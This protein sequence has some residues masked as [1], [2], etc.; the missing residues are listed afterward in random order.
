MSF[1]FT[2][3]SSGERSADVR[4]GVPRIPSVHVRA[5]SIT[6]AN[7]HKVAIGIFLPLIQNA[8]KQIVLNLLPEHKRKQEAG[9]T[10]FLAANRYAG[11]RRL[12]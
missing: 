7:V 9:R 11:L 2:G 8:R 3:R 4:V 12:Y 5:V 10:V 1:Y 6:V